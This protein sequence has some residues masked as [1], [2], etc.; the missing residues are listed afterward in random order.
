M[1]ETRVQSLGQENPL[2][3]GM[4]TH[5]CILAWRIPWTEEFGG[6]QSMRSQRV[7]HDW[8]TKH[9]YIYRFSL[10]NQTILNT[11]VTNSTHTQI[12]VHDSQIPTIPPEALKW[13]FQNMQDKSILLR[14]G[15]K[16]ELDSNATKTFI[17]LISHFLDSKLIIFW[18]FLVA[19]IYIISFSLKSTGECKKN[20]KV[21]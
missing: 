15:S 14:S 19:G 17:F 4:A 8:A 1:Q 2:K 18:L 13:I 5:S 6:L 10:W 3:K 16:N 12:T 7:R 21:L 9:T 11:N 20:N